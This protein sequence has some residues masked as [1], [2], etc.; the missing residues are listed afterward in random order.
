MKPVSRSSRGN[1]GEGAPIE[2]DTKTMLAV[3]LELRRGHG[4]D[5]I[6]HCVA[7]PDFGGQAGKA[8]N[9]LAGVVPIAPGLT[10]LAAGL[11]E[12][13]RFLQARSIVKV[14]RFWLPSLCGIRTASCMYVALLFAP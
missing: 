2:N 7:F 11:K 8:L 9:L 12:G 1:F 3:L 13:D 6:V 4:S 14:R 5:T 10:T